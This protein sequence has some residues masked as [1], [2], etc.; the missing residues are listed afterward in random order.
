[1]STEQ[2]P[3]LTDEERVVVA[4]FGIHPEDEEVSR[5]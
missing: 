2:A 4:R 5:G 3:E 1:M